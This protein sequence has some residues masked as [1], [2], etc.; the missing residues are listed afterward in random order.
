MNT[1][2]RRLVVTGLPCPPEAWEE[3]LG[4]SA[5]QRILSAAEVYDGCQSPDLREMS[6]IVTRAI[7][8]F[9]PQS[10]VC[11]DLG[12]PMT[13]LSL[14][15]LR[16]RGVWVNAR[17]TFFNGALRRVNLLKASQMLRVQLMPIEKAIKEVHS[18]GGVVDERLRK[19]YKK[20][21]AMY[22]RMVVFSAVDWLTSLTHL[23]KAIGFLPGSPLGI[24]MQ[25]I[26]S[27]NDP[28]I[29]FES[30]EQLRRDFHVQRFNVVPYGH[31]P[32]SGRRDRILPL[33][34]AF[35]TEGLLTAGNA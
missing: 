1:G 5:N 24:P 8:D 32:Y 17:V 9:E 20:I 30:I 16:R 22:R 4:K 7:A 13:L 3:F 23:E 12:V 10:I 28:Y 27:P 21:R 6:K 35:E 15:R 31:F 34:E 33:V 25:I 11:H 18:H 29:P 2:L 14:L 26:A 19:H